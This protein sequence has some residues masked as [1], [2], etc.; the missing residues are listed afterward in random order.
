M[1]IKGFTLIEI[2]MMIVMLCMIIAALI[3][4]IIDIT[5]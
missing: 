1:K 4:K 3:P 5:V 2:V